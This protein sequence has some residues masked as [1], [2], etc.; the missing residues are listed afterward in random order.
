MLKIQS[1]S[2]ILEEFWSAV[3]MHSFLKHFLKMILGNTCISEEFISLFIR[4][5][6]QDKQLR[7]LATQQPSNSGSRLELRKSF[8]DKPFKT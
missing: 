1:V 2:R 6:F 8:I 7:N 5:V 4:N 3:S